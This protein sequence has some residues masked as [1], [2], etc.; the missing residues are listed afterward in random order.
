M[1]FRVKKSPK[2]TATEE[3]EHSVSEPQSVS[4]LQ[5]VAGEDSLEEPLSAAAGINGQEDL[6]SAEEDEVQLLEEQLQKSARARHDQT[7]SLSEEMDQN[8]SPESDLGVDQ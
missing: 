8:E 4:V 3:N 1:L 2:S 7:A 5:S 6:L